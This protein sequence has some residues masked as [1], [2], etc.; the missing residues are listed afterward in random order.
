M[1][2]AF[3]FDEGYAEYAQVAMESLLETHRRRE[4]LTV[5]A[6]V[7]DIVLRERGD[8]LRRQFAGRA[9]LTL[10]NTGDG[11]RDLPVSRGEEQDYISN[12]M[13]LRLFLPQLIPARVRRLLY[14]DCDLLVAGDLSPLWRVP[15]R[16]AVLAAVQ[17]AWVRTFA[18]FNGLPGGQ[19]YDPGSEYFNSGVLLINMRAWREQDITGRCLT[20]LAAHAHELRLPDQDALNLAAHDRWVRLPKRWNH[21]SSWRL[22]PTEPEYEPEEARVMHFAGSRKPWTEGFRPG[23]R[24]D[25]YQRLMSDVLAYRTPA[26][27]GA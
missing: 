27:V 3:A 12:A 4:D 15:L 23:F 8:W 19:A 5:W 16:D 2:V 9:T 20:Y 25:R 24:Y 18:D 6:L 10:L 26:S 7:P 17:D 11:F 21:M 14:L 22:E 13:H 1:D